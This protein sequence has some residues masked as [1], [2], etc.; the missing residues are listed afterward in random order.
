A[1]S[2]GLKACI[3]VPHTP[4]ETTRARIRKTCAEVI[5][6]GKL[7]DD[8]NQRAKE[9]SQGA[10][11]EYVP[12]FEHPVLWEGHSTKVDEILEACPQVDAVVTSVGGGGL[13]AGI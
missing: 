6:H 9:L 3:V 1:A 11:I 10:D 8:A 7:W 12:A 13:L 4:P 5:V 2:L